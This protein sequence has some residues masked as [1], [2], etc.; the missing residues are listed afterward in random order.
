MKKKK[1]MNLELENRASEMEND[2]NQGE[3][4]QNKQ[5]D[6]SSEN[7]NQTV[8]NQ[9]EKELKET[10]LKNIL[11]EKDKAQTEHTE[12]EENWQDDLQKNQSEVDKSKETEN[13]SDADKNVIS[14][15]SEKIK[16]EIEE[17][18]K[19]KIPSSIE[20][21]S[22]KMKETDSIH[23]GIEFENTIKAGKKIPK[24]DIQ[25]EVDDDN[26]ENIRSE[27]IMLRTLKKQDAGAPIVFEKEHE[28][29]KNNQV[30]SAKKAN[31]M[32]NPKFS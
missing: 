18:I 6:L 26:K 8:C 9:K 15:K 28:K 21:Q 16:S 19:E 23:E 25:Y 20:N 13:D 17:N 2:N 32:D 4:Y 30:S 3:E 5:Q 10:S 1:N 7:K 29:Q 14:K 11:E 24:V 22:K 27:N 12:V 31:E